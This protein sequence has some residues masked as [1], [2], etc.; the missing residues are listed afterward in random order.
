MSAPLPPAFFLVPCPFHWGT[1]ALALQAAQS[2]PCC[3]PPPPPLPANN[4]NADIGQMIECL[5]A[6]GLRPLPIFING[7]EAHTVVR[8]HAGGLGVGGRL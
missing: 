5:E 7:V 8:H 3:L 6:Q 4:T 1:L 2:Q